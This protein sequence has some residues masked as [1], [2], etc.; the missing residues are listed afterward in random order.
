MVAVLAIKPV[1]F[2]V[3]LMIKQHIPA[4]GLKHLSNRG[5]RRFR[6]KH[7]VSQQS[8]DQANGK[9][10]IRQFQFKFRSHAIRFL[11]TAKDQLFTYPAGSRTYTKLPVSRNPGTYA[12]LT[13]CPESSVL[14]N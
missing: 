13:D 11:S 14:K 8:D 12:G 9:H 4:R 2:A 1:A 5:F 6:R 10:S 7:T 3:T